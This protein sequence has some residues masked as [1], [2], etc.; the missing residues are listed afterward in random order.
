MRFIL[1]IIGLMFTF[2]V[3][4]WHRADKLARP[5]RRRLLWRILIAIFMMAM[6]GTLTW[7]LLGRVFRENIDEMLPKSLVSAV[8]IWHFILLP[9][10]VIAAALTAL[11][12]SL[13]PMLKRRTPVSVFDP[14][15][16][17][18]REA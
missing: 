11:I 13:V 16:Q 18:R 5:M 7:M 14:E 6:L 17:T 9:V 10:T 2:D 12:G 4:W 1:T 3:I 15:A 8:F